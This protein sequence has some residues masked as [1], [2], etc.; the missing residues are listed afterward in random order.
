MS[1][2]MSSDA[3]AIAPA[4]PLSETTGR[5]VYTFRPYN[6]GRA[7]IWTAFALVLTVAPLMFSGGLGMTILSQMGIAIVACL[8]FNMLLGQGG[9]LSFGHAVYTGLATFI[10][11]HTLNRIGEGSL[12]EQ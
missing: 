3:E 10:A 12:D 9:M 7:V 5:E 11:V 4:V 1:A 2:L 6:V 8:S